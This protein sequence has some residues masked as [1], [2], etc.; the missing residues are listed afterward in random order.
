MSDEDPI[1]AGRRRRA[2]ISLPDAVLHCV[3]ER[4]RVIA[5]AS[6]A[7]SRLRP[8]TS[9]ATSVEAVP[10]VAAPIVGIHVRKLHGK[11]DYD[12]DLRDGGSSV[13]PQTGEHGSGLLALQDARL[14]L[15][16]GSNGTGKTS[17]LTL[18]FHALSHAGDRRHRSTLWS[19]RFEQ[20]VV[21]MA[22]GDTLAY[23]RD[24]GSTGPYMIEV[25][26]QSD[27]ARWHY[28]QPGIAED[29]PGERDVLRALERLAIQP[30]FL[31]DSRAF[32]SDLLPPFRR[33][34]RADYR[35]YTLH[36]DIPRPGVDD[37]V[38]A[39]R[40]ADL[41]SALESVRDY[42]SALVF[43]GAQ[44]GSQRVDSVYVN[45]TSAIVAH[46]GQ[47]GRPRKATIPD[48][49]GRI[50]E[51][52]ARAA[53]FTHY[54]L[55]P[56]FPTDDLLA[57]LRDA[58]PRNG[59]LLEHVLTPYLDG[60]S[61][62]M[63]ALKPGLDAIAAY[64]TVVNS[65]LEGKQVAFR[66]GQGSEITDLE[67]GENLQPGELSS[68]EKQILL[69]MSHLM[70]M[71]ERSRLFIVDEP[72]LSLNPEWQRHLMPAIL[73]ITGVGGMQIVAA[74]HSIE[75]M[76]RYRGRMRRLVAS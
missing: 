34:E 69:L 7:Y 20:F 47:V 8:V 68:G 43:R 76:A 74:T 18:L 24:A 36:G 21:E 10:G 62:R 54:G 50:A 51:I 13:T 12:L 63:D 14:T 67:S 1:P 29:E 17:L 56:R 45:V 40:D 15:L 27:S 41:S 2:G 46:A 19:M 61:Q 16:Y 32:H 37:V 28:T 75:I 33:D 70:A 23:R 5:R 58:Q 60:F 22:N 65:F 3:G 4:R 25:Q 71:R 9:H 64:V 42:L 35:Y 11:Y 55:L 30:A 48:L 73:E 57:A 39:R 66:L 49:R 31:S 52:G 6:H 26:V 53:P 38:A 72:E 44:Q 59:P